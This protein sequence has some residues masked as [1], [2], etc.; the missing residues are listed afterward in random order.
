MILRTQFVPRDGPNGGSGVF[1]VTLTHY[2]FR[3]PGGGCVTFFA[4]VEGLITVTL[5][6]P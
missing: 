6:S 5:P 2:G 3:V 1:G 4:T